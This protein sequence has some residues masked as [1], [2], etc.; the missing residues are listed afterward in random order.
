[1]HVVV[2]HHG[3]AFKKTKDL[4]QGPMYKG[5]SHVDKVLGLVKGDDGIVRPFQVEKACCVSCVV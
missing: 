3:G 5:K 1:M 2:R 4:V